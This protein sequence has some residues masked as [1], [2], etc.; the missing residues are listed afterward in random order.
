[1]PGSILVLGATGHIGAPLVA[2]LLG[3]GEK[4]KATSRKGVAV[5]GAEAVALDMAAPANF[6][7][8]FEGIDRMYLMVPGG[9]LNVVE[10]TA[11]FLAAAAKRNVKVVMQSVMGVDADDSIPYRQIEL[12][13]IKSGLAHVILR[14]NWFADNFHTY[15]IHGVKTGTISVP[16]GEGKS[17]FI[18]VRDIAASAASALTTNKND[19]KAFNLTGPEALSYAE[20]AAILSKAT[21]REIAY[22]PIDDAAFVKG[23]IGAGVPADYAN[24]LASIFHPV[25]E[26]WTAKV[27]GDVEALTGRNP[28]SVAQYAK[29]HAKELA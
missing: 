27:T 2:E 26:G 10:L 20:A 7:A 19:G 28:R 21:G 13:L 11:P 1:M 24:F 25:R 22:Q 23:L 9:H 12:A 17:S 18:D 15:W 14:P 4:V 16:A 8:A 5:K 3:R 29:D 6:E